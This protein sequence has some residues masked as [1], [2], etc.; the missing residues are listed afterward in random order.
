MALVAGQPASLPASI[1]LCCLMYVVV[2]RAGALCCVVVVC[3][4]TLCCV[5]CRRGLLYFVEVWVYRVVYLAV[6]WCKL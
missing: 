4:Y 1:A 6:F 5:V 2:V 3:V